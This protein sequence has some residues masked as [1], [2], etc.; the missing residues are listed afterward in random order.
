MVSQTPKKQKKIF[1]N[2][3]QL[4]FKA[5]GSIRPV[6]LLHVV[7]QLVRQSYQASEQMQ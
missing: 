1:L 5:E 2:N 4:F 3:A 6:F 7:K